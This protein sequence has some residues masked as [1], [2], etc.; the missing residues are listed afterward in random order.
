M[1]LLAEALEELKFWENLPIG[2]YSPFMLPSSTESL[3]MDASDIG[4]GMYFQ[5]YLFS[6]TVEYRQINVMDLSTLDR[7][8]ERFQKE[9]KPGMV[10]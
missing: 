4:I 7:A 2:L 9:I 1:F 6:E 10:T 8:L 5:V 3:D